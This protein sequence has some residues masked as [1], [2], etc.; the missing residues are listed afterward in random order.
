MPSRL[1]RLAIVLCWAVATGL[2]IRRDVVPSLVIGPPPDMRTIVKT[3]PRPEGPVQWRI[4]VTD[5]TDPDTVQ[6]VGE[7]ITDMA[8]SSDGWVTYTT[9]AQ[10]DA[11]QVLDGSAVSPERGEQIAIKGSFV[12]E[13]SGSLENFRV[14]VHMGRGGPEILSV[15]GSVQGNDLV[16]SITGPITLLNG[17]R[18]FPYE[19]RSMV[20][21]SLGPLDWLPGLNVGQN[22]SSRM[23]SPLTGQIQEVTLSV[24]TKRVLTWDSN[25]VTTL[26]LVTRSGP[27]E[28][29]TWVRP[30]GLVLR[31]E[32][33]FPLARL[34]LE[35]VP[36][37]VAASER[38][39]P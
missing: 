3:N 27:L 32:V 33:P 26:E 5:E 11:Q 7:A 12:V 21:N 17:R 29:R 13:P 37:P 4:L 25:P 8:R 28:L 19:P 23:V 16:V 18:R 2:M 39:K 14:G 20:Q 35:R 22:W 6:P 30:D 10:F 34:V 1:A 9:N 24:E 38:T 36:Q 15:S 31:Q